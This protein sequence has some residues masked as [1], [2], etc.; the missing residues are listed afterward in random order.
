VSIV[1]LARVGWLKTR[2]SDRVLH[3]GAWVV[4]SW[5]AIGTMTFTVY[6]FEGVCP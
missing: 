2:L 5:T 1:T 3:I 6:A 4:S